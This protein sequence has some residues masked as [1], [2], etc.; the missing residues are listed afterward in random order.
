MAGDAVTR[1]SA[2]G[3]SPPT[4][5][6]TRD[7]TGARLLDGTYDTLPADL[8][9]YLAGRFTPTRRHVPRPRAHASLEETRPARPDAAPRWA[10]AFGIP[11]R[12]RVPPARTC[13]EAGE[14]ARREQ[15]GAWA[16]SG[17]TCCSGTRAREDLP[18]R[19]IR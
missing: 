17:S 1:E 16:R 18:I 13:I 14:T 4:A 8:R 15:R 7:R 3:G 11:R 6:A 10:A 12:S 2:Y 9:A 19:P 5:P